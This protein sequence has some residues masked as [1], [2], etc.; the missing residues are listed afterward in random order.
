VPETR[1]TL[2]YSGTSPYKVRA[3][4]GLIRGV[5]VALARQRLQFCGRDA[6]DEVIKVLDSAVANAE[7]N[8]HLPADELY[9][10]R[11]W[12]DE[13]PTQKRWRPRARGR[14]TRIRKRT[15]HVTVVVARY[16]DEELARRA[17]QEAASGRGVPDRRRRVQR[18]RRAEP[19]PVAADETG[20]DETG[21]DETA[22]A[23][24]AA[25]AAAEA[26]QTVDT[27]T[28][29]VG[30]EEVGT[31]TVDTP[32]EVVGTEEGDSEEV[33]GDAGT[34]ETGAVAPAEAAEPDAK[35]AR[36]AKKLA[37]D[38]PAAKNKEDE[39]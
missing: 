21:V 25:V 13:G 33:T 1:A 9:V 37:A 29:V 18:R 10:T 5:E 7:E 12:A 32:T 22:A 6:A 26:T 36:G 8:D 16:S 30:T 27:P 4:L 28:E 35:P 3:V 15:S 23:E 2:R 34:E 24:A 14:G 19:A 31:E 39:A 11:A 38:K 20:V 17:R